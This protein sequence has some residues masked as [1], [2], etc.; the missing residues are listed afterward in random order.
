MT[1]NQELRD[2]T[3]FLLE[4]RD[5][6]AIKNCPHALSKTDRNG[7]EIPIFDAAGNKTYVCAHKNP[8]ESDSDYVARIQEDVAFVHRLVD[9]RFQYLVKHT[10]APDKVGWAKKR[11]KEAK[12]EGDNDGFENLS[13]DD[14]F[15]E[16]DDSF[17]LEESSEKKGADADSEQEYNPSPKCD[18]RPVMRDPSSGRT[19]GSALADES[20]VS[21]D[22]LDSDKAPGPAPVFGR[23]Q[24]LRGQ[25]VSEYLD[26]VQKWRPGTHAFPILEGYLYGKQ[27]I[28]GRPFKDH[29]FN[30]VAAKN[31]VGEIW[32]YLYKR[33]LPTMVNKSFEGVTGAGGDIGDP[34]PPVTLPDKP[35]NEASDYQAG[36]NEAAD[37]LFKWISDQWPRFDINDKIALLCV[38]FKVSLNDPRIADMTT[39]RRQAFYNRKGHFLRMM[40]YLHDKQFEFDEVR[41]LLVGPLQSMLR[42]IAKKD[43]SCKP[44]L[45]FLAKTASEPGK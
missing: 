8:G 17:D 31:G 41:T 34:T 36:V 22:K 26:I 39:V 30:V 10:R 23:K 25:K 6:C 33:V 37:C 28:S 19:I 11:E 40:E 7:V 2:L 32:G 42:T 13:P 14:D 45:D 18:D 5:T 38:S 3:S 29:L 44:F 4:W 15:L 21:Q 9:G 27:T 20:N 12:S 24:A 16:E 43:T 35:K 1:E